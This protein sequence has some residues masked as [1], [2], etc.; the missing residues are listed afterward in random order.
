MSRDMVYEDVPILNRRQ[1]DNVVAGQNNATILLGRDRVDSV[2]TGYGARENGGGKSAGAIHAVVGRKGSDPSVLDDAATLYLSQKADP[3]VQAGTEEIG[4]KISGRPS[5]ILRADCVRIVPR[6]DLKVSV[7][8]AYL[9]MTAEGKIVIEGD[10]QLGEGAAERIIRGDAF[11][12]YWSGPGHTHPTPVGLSGP[13]Q[14]LPD[15][16][17]SP[18]NKVI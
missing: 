18:S 5:A 2:D 10:I 6:T 17:L 7:G 11:A 9:M 13:P 14:P 16:L 1:G 3:D 4:S 12:R 15:F 8:K